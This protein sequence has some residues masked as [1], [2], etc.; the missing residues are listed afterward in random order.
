MQPP[1]RQRFQNFQASNLLW[2][3][4]TWSIKWAWSIFSPISQLPSHVTF[5]SR[6]NFFICRLGSPMRTSSVA[7]PLLYPAKELSRSTYV[8]C[9]IVIDATSTSKTAQ[10]MEPAPIGESMSSVWYFFFL[11]L[12]SNQWYWIVCSTQTRWHNGKIHSLSKDF[13]ILFSYC[14]IDP[15]PTKHSLKNLL[16]SFLNQCV[17]SLY[18]LT[19]FLVC[20]CNPV[21]KRLHFVSRATT[22]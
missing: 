7:S 9:N 20:A 12:L 6:L 22:F 8:V 21:Q 2:S 16:L 15:A 18:F 1:R 11:T 13:A 3:S 17:D 19:T 5:K 14:K 4:N 10:S